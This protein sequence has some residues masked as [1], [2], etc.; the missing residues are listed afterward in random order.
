[1]DNRDFQVMIEENDLIKLKINA[2]LFYRGP[3]SRKPY[4]IRFIR[5]VRKSYKYYD[6]EIIFS[7]LKTDVVSSEYLFTTWNEAINISPI[8]E[9]ITS[10]WREIKIDNTKLLLEDSQQIPGFDIKLG[11]MEASITVEEAE[12]LWRTLAKKLGYQIDFIK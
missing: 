4:K 12:T 7:S 2:I 9:K 5:I 6:T 3:R 11:N 10:S 8:R 1:M